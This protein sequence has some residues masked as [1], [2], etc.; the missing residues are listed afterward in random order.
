M[1]IKV[2]IKSVYGQDRIYPVCDK[3]KMFTALTGN[4]TLSQIDIVQ[5]KALGFD[6]EVQ[7][8]EL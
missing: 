8:P 1:T 7:A 4:K 3:A 2:E 6:V 5:I